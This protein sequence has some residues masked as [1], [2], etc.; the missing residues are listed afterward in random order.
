MESV[1]NRRAGIPLAPR[2]AIDPPIQLSGT[3]ADSKRFEVLPHGDVTEIRLV[4]PELTDLVIQNELS[5]QLLGVVTDQQPM[6]VVVN[7]AAVR[8]CSSG[9]IESLLALRKTVKRYGGEVRLCE[10]RGV[11]RQ[12]LKVLNLDGTLF[13]IKESVKEAIDSF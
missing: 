4:D 13:Q 11:V 5:E 3:M 1:K 8:I 10:V 9:A 12:A 7:M 6:K 2:S